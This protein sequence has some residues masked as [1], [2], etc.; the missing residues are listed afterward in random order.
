[1]IQKQKITPF[2]WFDQN[3]EEA[4]RFYTSIFKDS[5]VVSEMRWGAG[6]PGAL[7]DRDVP[8]QQPAGASLKL[9]T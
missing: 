6:W 7:R 9:R 4:V 2:L 5:K 3:P 8:H 1:M